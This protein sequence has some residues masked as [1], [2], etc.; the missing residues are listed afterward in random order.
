MHYVYFL[1][2]YSECYF[3]LLMLS[4]LQ[5]LPRHARNPLSIMFVFAVYNDDDDDDD[6]DGD[7]DG[8]D[9]DDDDGDADDV[10]KCLYISILIIWLLQDSNNN[11]IKTLLSI[12]PKKIL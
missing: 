5:H 9:G 8:D 2:Y 11:H 12:S 1:N 6:G 3:L 7:D 4:L 10:S